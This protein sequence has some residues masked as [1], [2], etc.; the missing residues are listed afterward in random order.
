MTFTFDLWYW[1]LSP[2]SRHVMNICGKFYWNPFTKWRD[3]T[4]REIAAGRP[5]GRPKKNIGPNAFA[6]YCW[7]R[8]RNIFFALICNRYV[9]Y[10]RLPNF[11]TIRHMHGWVILGDKFRV[12]SSRNW[13]T[14]QFENQMYISQTLPK[15]VLF[16]WYVVSFRSQ[17]A[18]KVK[19]ALFDT[20]CKNKGA[21][22]RN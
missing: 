14:K 22:G 20:P 1:I 16:V 18:S 4:S 10:T 9:C 21:G 8:H 7:R 2:I 19:L 15:F 5:D 3:T 11:C 17:S 12:T 6:T 13:V